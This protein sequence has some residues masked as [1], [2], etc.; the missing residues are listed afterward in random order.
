MQR[1]SDGPFATPKKAAGLDPR[2]ELILSLT[3]MNCNQ[4]E[5]IKFQA[6]DLFGRTEQQSDLVRQHSDLVRQ[7][8]DLAQLLK[9][10]QER[11]DL[12]REQFAKEREQE[13]KKHHENV[14]MLLQH[15]TG[16]SLHAGGIAPVAATHIRDT[17]AHPRKSCGITGSSTPIVQGVAV[18]AELGANGG[19]LLFCVVAAC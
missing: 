19:K 17:P 9:H 11:Q 4:S 5:T 7:H 10:G 18:A 8:S 1:T 2:D 6:R 13:Q 14:T 3:K 12:E 16:Q 15:I